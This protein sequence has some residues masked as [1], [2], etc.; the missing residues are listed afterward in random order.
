VAHDTP[1]CVIEAHTSVT[2]SDGAEMLQHAF[3][4]AE[5]LKRETTYELRLYEWPSCVWNQGRV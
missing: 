5:F 1:R 4:S 3:R 2:T